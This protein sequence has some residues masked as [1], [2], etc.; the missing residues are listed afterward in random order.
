M[1]FPMT[2]LGEARSLLW[3]AMSSILAA[4]AA[5]FRLTDPPVASHGPALG[6]FVPA[7]EHD[8]QLI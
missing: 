5:L 1:A 7:E 4:W 3:L 6:R 8:N 2:F